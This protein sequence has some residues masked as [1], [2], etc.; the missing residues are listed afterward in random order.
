MA[1]D[2]GPLRDI[3]RALEPELQERAVLQ[4]GLELQRKEEAEMAA[5][6]KTAVEQM[7][8]TDPDLDMEDANKLREWHERRSHP[9]TPTA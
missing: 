1:G 2:Q 7:L 6:I 9:V 3:I 4:F 5:A 8:A